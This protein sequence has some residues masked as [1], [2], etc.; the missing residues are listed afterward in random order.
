MAD[1][2]GRRNTLSLEVAMTVHRR[3]IG[4]HEELCVRP[5]A[6]PAWQRENLR[7]FWQAIAL[8]CSSEDAAANAGVSTP[9]GPRWFRSAGGM[10]STHLAPSA[11]PHRGTI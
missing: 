5:D 6:P 4:A 8:G 2:S 10:P 9:L 3:R 7:Q 11:N 1:S